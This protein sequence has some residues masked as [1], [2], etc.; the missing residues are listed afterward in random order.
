MSRIPIEVV[1][2]YNELVSCIESEKTNVL[3][4]R[5]KNQAKNLLKKINE[6][7]MPDFAITDKEG[8]SISI[9]QILEKFLSN[10]P[11]KRKNDNKSEIKK[12]IRAIET[13][14][15]EIKD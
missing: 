3:P 5:E 12:Q 9:A 14:Y 4:L 11:D 1:E 13:L 6:S 7:R 10:V 8:N 2:R 15:P